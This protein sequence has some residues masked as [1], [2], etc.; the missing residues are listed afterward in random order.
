MTEATS[1]LQSRF[2]QLHNWAGGDLGAAIRAASASVS[3][4][5]KPAGIP[6]IDISPLLG[7]DAS[8][9]AAT[10]E[11]IATACEEIG[12]MVVTGHGVS[13][14]VVESM[15]DVTTEFFDLSAEEKMKYAEMSEEVRVRACARSKG[16]EALRI[17]NFT[18]HGGANIMNNL[19]IDACI[20][21][22]FLF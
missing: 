17:Y 18:G 8:L 9:K 1:G 6:V 7:S 21:K 15:W 11:A 19:D 2:H 3:T 4:P 13:R 16:D 10:V 5:A 14:D 20:M 22:A 12:F